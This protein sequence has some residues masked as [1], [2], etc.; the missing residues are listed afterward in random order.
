MAA[1]TPNQAFAYGPKVLGLHFHAEL[2]PRDM[3]KWLIGHSV[4][5]AKAGIEDPTGEAELSDAQT[6]AVPG[7]PEKDDER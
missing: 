4:E 3:E 2:V 6:T 1:I 7:G 5:L